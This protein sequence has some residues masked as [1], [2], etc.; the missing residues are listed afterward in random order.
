MLVEEMSTVLEHL[1]FNVRSLCDLVDQ[2]P[3]F[4]DGTE[5]VTVAV[6]EKDR[7]SQADEEIVVAVLIDRRPDTYEDM[8][9]QLP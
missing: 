2:R 1:Q 9:A 5:F 3:E 7:F 6:D 8:T 4:V